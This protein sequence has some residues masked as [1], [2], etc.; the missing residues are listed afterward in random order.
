MITYTQ[1]L[2]N[3]EWEAAPNDNDFS[4]TWEGFQF[5]VVTDGLNTVKELICHGDENEVLRHIYMLEPDDDL[6]TVVF[7]ET[8][9]DFDIKETEV[10]FV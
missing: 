3:D 6:S 4:V 9:C 2:Q 1:R 5:T 8:G 10:Y 7:R